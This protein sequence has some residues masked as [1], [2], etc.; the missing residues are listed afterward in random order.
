MSGA[1]SRYRRLEWQ[2]AAICLLLI[3]ITLIVAVPSPCLAAIKVFEREYTYQASE[4]DSKLSSR[5]VSLAEVKRLLLEELG[6]YLESITEVKNFQ[7]TKDQITALTAGIVRVEVLDERWDGKIYWLKARIAADPDGVVKSIDSLRRDRE[8]TRELEEVKKRVD[9][10]LAEN[11]RL[12]EELNTAG[13]KLK[14]KKQEEYAQGIKELNATEWVQRGL[15]LVKSGNYNEAME[16]YTKAIELDPKLVK[17]YIFRC[18]VYDKL[19]NYR[20]AI[21]GLHPWS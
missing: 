13:G 16:A 4:A 21:N 5:T 17:A 1:N 14:E 7:L 12:K 10:L 19:G 2:V 15:S 20:Q 11:K 3:V 9:S 18:I 8:K 6:T